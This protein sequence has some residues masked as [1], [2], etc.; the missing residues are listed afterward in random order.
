M[1]NKNELLTE[2]KKA[3]N[4]GLLNDSLKIFISNALT[5]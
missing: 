3:R 5:T 2:I 4:C 1:T